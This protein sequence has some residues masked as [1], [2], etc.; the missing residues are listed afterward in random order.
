MCTTL[1]W[2]HIN[3]SP[4]F[5]WTLLVCA[6]L[7]IATILYI[8]IARCSPGKSQIVKPEQGLNNRLLSKSPLSPK[9]RDGSGMATVTPCLS[10]TVSKIPVRSPSTFCTWSSSF[11]NCSF[12][13]TLRP[14]KGQA[15][16]SEIVFNMTNPRWA[17]TG[18]WIKCKLLV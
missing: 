14:S 7:T 5:W 6:K 1:T 4:I 12:G 17:I 3:I 8:Y 18:D 13:A 9:V 2:T 16:S 11:P 15:S 10:Q